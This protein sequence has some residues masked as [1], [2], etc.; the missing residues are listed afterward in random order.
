MADDLS[1]FYQL[2]QY[3][4]LEQSDHMD[5]PMEIQVTGEVPK[6]I[7]GSLYRDG[8][9][10]FKIGPTAWNHLFD[11]YAVLQRWTICDGKVTF[12]ASIL[13]SENYNKS[14]KHRRIVGEGLGLNFPDPCETLFGRLF[15]RFM[16]SQ[17]VS[18]NTNVNMIELGDRLFALTESLSM[19]EI[20]PDSLTVKERT[21]LITSQGSL[22]ITL[23]YS[24]HNSAFAHSL[25]NQKRHSQLYSSL[26]R[27][28]STTGS[29]AQSFQSTCERE[30]SDYIAVHMGTAHPHK[31]K[32]GTAIFYGT[33]MNPN[34]SY[35]F[36]AIPPQPDPTKSPFANAK[37]VATIPS[38]WKMNISYTH[39]FGMTENY[40]VHL[41]QPLTMNI[42]RALFYKQLGMNLADVLVPHEEESMDILLVDRT[43]GQRLPI[44]YKA[45][46]GIVFHFINCYEESNHVVCD[47]CFIPKGAKS[48]HRIYFNLIV[49]DLKSRF[50]LQP[51]Y[52]RFVLPLALDKAEEGKNLV[53]L[54]DTTATA[55]LEKGNKNVVC[56]TPEFFKE[57]MFTDFPAINYDYNGAKHRYCYTYSSLSVAERML[58]KFDLIEKTV[59]TYDVSENH[60]PGEPVF[61]PRPGATREDDGV[62]LS[63]IIAA[64]ASVQSYMVVLDA[65]TFEEIARASLPSDIKMSLTFHG[66][67]TD[68]KL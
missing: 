35:N 42:P 64:N 63:T 65:S 50:H 62:I 12:Q 54:P 23:T 16:P 33:N 22:V 56:V 49:E 32:D 67:F 40:F 48:V 13:D 27:V 47:V 58:A 44:T 51:T 34:K 7:D 61:V 3:F 31:L 55:V 36:I 24:Y 10:L 52:A 59:K 11:G 43:T 8:P 19:N 46:E 17:P 41:E 21:A 53:S 25:I 28:K 18:D 5:K 68:K 30:I 15:N 14:A 39:S 20:N 4:H 26:N 38:R 66:I 9:G 1:T 6:W 37:V 60:S 45:P 57:N 2:P 29:R